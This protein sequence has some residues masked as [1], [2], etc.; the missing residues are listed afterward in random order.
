MPHAIDLAVEDARWET[1]IP[2]L[3]ALVTRAVE[4][5][6]AVAD[7]RGHQVVAQVGQVPI[8]GRARAFQ[9]LLE[10]L[11][12]DRIPGRSENPVQRVDAF[13]TFHVGRVW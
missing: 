8:N 10:P 7:H 1:A 5:G 2:G 13:D 11:N 12:C 6:L 3:E 9:V 4:A